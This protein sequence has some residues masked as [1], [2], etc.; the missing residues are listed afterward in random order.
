M[1]KCYKL[2]IQWVT[3]TSAQ[4]MRLEIQHRKEYHPTCDVNLQHLS[5]ITLWTRPNTPSIPLKALLNNVAPPD[6]FKKATM[7]ANDTSQI[8]TPIF[9]PLPPGA[10]RHHASSLRS[11]P[12]ETAR[13]R[14]LPPPRIVPYSCVQRLRSGGGGGWDVHR[15]GGR[16]G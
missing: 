15:G 3:L 9:L 12:L 5:F 16:Y 11:Y 2:E 7:R 13:S 6:T 1:V 8:V 10:N 14:A 4:Q